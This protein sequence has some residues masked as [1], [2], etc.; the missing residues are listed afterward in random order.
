M[1]FLDVSAFVCAVVGACYYSLTTTNLH[2]EGVNFHQIVS[3]SYHV[4]TLELLTMI[5]GTMAV[6]VLSTA[7]YVLLDKKPLKLTLSNRDGTIKHFEVVHWV[8]FTTLTCWTWVL[9]GIYFAL[10]TYCGYKALVNES[11]DISDA[12]VGVLW[13]IY[14]CTFSVSILITFIVTYVLIPGGKSRGLDVST[15]FTIPS[16]LMH[17][18]NIIF[19]VAESCINKLPIDMSH[20][21]FVVLYGVLYVIFAW[22]W[23]QFR[24]VFYY[25]FLDY[26]RPYALFWYIG[27]IIAVSTSALVLSH[28]TAIFYLL[29][30]IVMQ[31]FFHWGNDLPS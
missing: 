12:F 19:M 22:V 9:I 29:Y 21:P 2:F 16:L 6:I 1:G 28:I 31:C 27:L 15:F 26:A 4:I 20:L 13:V 18:A 11:D 8:R 23:F 25:F 3:S 14:E 30:T 24:G 7:L 5:R 10:T 17:N